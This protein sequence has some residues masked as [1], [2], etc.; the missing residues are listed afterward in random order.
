MLLEELIEAEAKICERSVIFDLIQ[1]EQHS[2]GAYVGPAEIK[3]LQIAAMMD[4]FDDL[5]ERDFGV[6]RIDKGKFANTGMLHNRIHHKLNSRRTHLDI[7]Q[8]QL[9]QVVWNTALE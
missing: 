5:L 8:L 3:I 7:D 9:L 6:L 1:K 4:V 2:L